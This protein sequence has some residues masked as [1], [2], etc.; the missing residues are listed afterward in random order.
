MIVAYGKKG[1]AFSTAEYLKNRAAR[2]LPL[3]YAAMILMLAYYFIRV[4]ILHTPAAYE[5]NNEDTF[6]NA[7]L[8]QS[9]FPAKALT[10]NPPAW[11]LSV[12]A[13]FYFSFP[14]IFNRFYKKLSLHSFIM[15]I[16]ALFFFSQLLF[17][18]LIYKWPGQLYYFYF[19]PLL[20]L[21][22]FLAGN[23]VGALFVMQKKPMRYAAYGVVALLVL[24]VITL[25]SDT[26]PVDFHNGLFA[27]FFAPMLFLFAMSQGAVN[28]L[29]SRKSL[30]FLGEISYGVYIFQFPVY[31]FFT[32]TLTYFGH[33]ITPVVFYGY[34]AVLLI[35]SAVA[36]VTIELPLRKRIRKIR[37][38]NQTTTSQLRS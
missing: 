34:L 29:F 21:N 38:L 26:S 30:E 25:R 2:I 32:A 13:F 27:I 24:S 14:F 12:E 9:W 23:A 6:L 19:Q 28:R 22:E 17:H 37:L 11:S 1:R 16:A 36:H 35:V 20:R 4:N 18:F 15:W 5:V 8:V 33:K 10:L 7:L 31:F 3:Y